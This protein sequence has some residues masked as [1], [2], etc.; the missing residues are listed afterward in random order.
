MGTNCNKTCGIC[1]GPTRVRIST[2]TKAPTTTIKTTTEN[3]GYKVVPCKDA[4]HPSL[5]FIHSLRCS[6][7]NKYNNRQ[8]KNSLVHNSINLYTLKHAPF[9]NSKWSPCYLKK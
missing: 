5:V 2:T 3:D 4:K 8:L 6:L 7:L 1:T 9:K